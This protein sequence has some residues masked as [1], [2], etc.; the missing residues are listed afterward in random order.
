MR[1]DGVA[2]LVDSTALAG[3]G[4]LVAGAGSRSAGANL[5]VA[6]GSDDDDFEVLAHLAGI[7][8]GVL[9]HAGTP[10]R[11]LEVG[12]GAGVGA[13]LALGLVATCGV[14]GWVAL[15]VNVEAGA[16]VGGL[17]FFGAALDVVAAESVQAK[18]GVGTDGG[19]QVLEGLS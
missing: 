15:D 1:A 14:E 13:V 11:A 19:I 17:A 2:G 7:G 8:G 10:E 12:D 9:V 16:E 4:G 5:L 6:V 18:V 3:L